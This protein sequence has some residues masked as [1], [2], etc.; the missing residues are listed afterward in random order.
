[1]MPVLRPMLCALA[2]VLV[3]TG[4]GNSD[5]SRPPLPPQA[6]TATKAT[7]QVIP[8]ALTASGRLLAREEV[9]VGADLNGFRVTRVL[10]EEGEWVRRG[11]VLATLDDSLLRPQV[12]QLRATLAQQEVAA[13]QAAAQAAR[14]EG[15][16]G[17]GV[18]SGEAIE[19]RRFAARSA[20]AALAAT[21][22]QL[23][24]VLVRQ[25]HLLIRAPTNGLVLERTVRPGDTSSTGTPMFRLARDG[26]IEHYAELSESDI[27]RIGIGDPAEVTLPSGKRL[28]GKV[29]LIGTRIE[30]QT[31]LAIAR[32]ALPRDNE[33]RQ[34]GFAEAR[35]TRNFTVLAV[36]AGAVQFDADGASVKVIDGQDRIHRMKVRT[37]KRARGLVEIASGISEGALVA[38]KGSAFVLDG[39]KV[40]VTGEAK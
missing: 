20:R 8:G 3:L 2:A 34:G 21:R 36:P 14:V 6:V 25:S 27:A 37:G 16:D 26:L 9:A 12:D 7:K 18:L 40:H 35:F 22:A 32:I 17:Q 13:E 19:S 4:C 24:D 28:A 38:V 23:K 15:L 31:G 33:L 10:V 29:R 5:S 1:M 11:Q 39:D 30:G